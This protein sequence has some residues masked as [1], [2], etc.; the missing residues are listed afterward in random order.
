MNAIQ[1]HHVKWYEHTRP[2]GFNLKS[3]ELPF[4]SLFFILVAIY[5]IEVYYIG[6]S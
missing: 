2:A 4:H 5:A 6:L 3:V 1:N